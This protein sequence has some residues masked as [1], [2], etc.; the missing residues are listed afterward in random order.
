[1]NLIEKAIRLAVVAHKDQVRKSDNSPYIV[2]PLMVARLVDTA[3]F[4]EVVVAAAVVHD[5]LEDTDVDEETLR[6][7]L[8]DEV[9]AIVKAVSEDTSLS[10]EVRKQLYITTVAHAQEAAKAVSVADKIHNAESL[11]DAHEK[12]GE[13]IWRHFN[14]P[15][16]Q[17]LWFERTLLETLEK[18]WHHPLL[19]Q[20]RALVEKMETLV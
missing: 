16:A 18:D 19:A 4:S 9:V 10:W 3:G 14:R 20:Y 7:E 15:R 6:R 13:V 5:V 8:G 11:I 1:M 12:Q 17:K 2:H